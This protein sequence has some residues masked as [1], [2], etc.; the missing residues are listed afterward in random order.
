ML[1]EP[2]FHS[3]QLAQPVLPII[4]TTR[5][6]A[7]EIDMSISRRTFVET[8]AITAAAASILNVE[9]ATAQVQATPIPDA[10]A[11]GHQPRPLNFNPAEL[12]GLSE[13]LINSHWQNN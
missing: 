10:F 6:K 4:I 12:D 9:H 5:P 1:R 8:L 7:R 11:G 2:A 13:K 3:R